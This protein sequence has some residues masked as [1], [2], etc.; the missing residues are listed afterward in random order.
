MVGMHRYNPLLLFLALCVSVTLSAQH[1]RIDY[2]GGELPN[3]EV[4]YYPGDILREGYDEHAAASFANCFTIKYNDEE[5]VTDLTLLRQRRWFWLQS[6]RHLYGYYLY[7]DKRY[8]ET[9]ED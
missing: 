2:V 8:G 7:D 5:E 4:R 3:C 6:V 9:L 1:Y